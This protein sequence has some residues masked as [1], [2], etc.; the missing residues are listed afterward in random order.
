MEERRGSFAAIVAGTMAGD[1]ELSGG[2][3]LHPA[4]RRDTLDSASPEL[5]CRFVR[6]SRKQDRYAMRKNVKPLLP[7]RESARGRLLLWLYL[8][9]GGLL[10]LAL[11][12]MVAQGEWLAVLAVLSIGA[13]PLVLALLCTWVERRL[14]AWR[15]R[16]RRPGLDND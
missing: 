12:R 14:R 4:V 7:E 1:Q 2:R 5:G 10:G 16:R 6:E 15:T 8:I 3:Q 13:L 9:P 11:A